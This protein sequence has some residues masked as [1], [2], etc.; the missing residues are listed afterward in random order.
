[1]LMHEMLPMHETRRAPILLVALLLLASPLVAAI[2]GEGALCDRDL[3]KIGDGIAIVFSPDLAVPGNREFYESLGFLY[4]ESADW[5]DVLSQV[6]EVSEARPVHT[7]VVESHGAN[8]NGLKL[9]ASPD[10]AASRSY[11]SVGGLQHA[12]AATT[13]RSIL[14]SA[15]NAGRLFRPGIYNRL[16]RFVGDPLFLPATLGIVDAPGGFRATEAHPRVFRR[17]QSNLETL[18]EG[19]W[20]ELP[21]ESIFPTLSKGERKFVVSTML[22]QFLSG[23]ERLQLV[24]SGFATAKSR[25]DL[26]RKESEALFLSFLASLETGAEKWRNEQEAANELAERASVFAPS[27][28]Q[29][30]TPR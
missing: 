6:R 17:K 28:D 16:D 25:D 19:D 15:C 22:I 12:L 13:I 7:V 26:S 29:V 10:P 9:Q 3:P 2:D 24:D 11:A 20:T 14:L 4:L 23:D 30:A 8:G 1:M 21:R 27:T 18:V 5:N